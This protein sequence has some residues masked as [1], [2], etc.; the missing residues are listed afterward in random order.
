MNIRKN[1][2]NAIGWRTKRKIVVIESDDWGSIRTQ[3]KKDYKEMLAK[4]LLVDL[5]NFTKFDALES[6]LDLENLFEVLN[7]HKDSTGRAALFTPMCIVANPDFEKIKNSGFEQ[8]HYESFIQT[9][10]RYPQ[11]DKVHDLWLEGI[12]ERLFVPALH[13]REHL[14]VSRWMNLLKSGNE[15]ILTAFEHQSLGGAYYKGN[16]ISEY[17]G[18]F[19]P[20]L[21]SDIPHL[22]KILE[23]AVVLFTS[24]CGYKPTHFIAPNRE[25][26]KELDVT[27]AASGVKYLTMSKLRRYPMGDEKYGREFYWMGKKNNLGQVIIARNC[28]FEP[29]DPLH[30]DW[31]SSCLY[32]ID[33]AFKWR[34]PAVISSHRVNF[35][36]F[37]NEANAIYGLK[38][39]DRLLKTIIKKWPD[40][41]FMTSTELGK[42]INESK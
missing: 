14:S 10:K 17:L 5:S 39:L 6:N 2:S 33:N 22:Q 36:G 4:G 28:H 15:G 16:E 40:V 25:G 12:R 32:E 7:K 3:S 20:D 24:I 42:T 38:E 35:V 30:T 1:L 37:I 9:C 8:Y 11:H 29:S 27:L 31:V 41:E 34:K 26:P 18:A 23:E 13:G 19:H 21:S